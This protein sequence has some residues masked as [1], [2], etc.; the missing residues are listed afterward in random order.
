VYLEQYR[1]NFGRLEAQTWIDRDFSG[2]VQYLMIPRETW[3][4]PPLRLAQG[5]FWTPKP[6]V[7]PSTFVEISDW[8]IPTCLAAPTAIW[9][10]GFRSRH[11]RRRAGLCPQCGYHLR[12]SINRCPECGTPIP[13]HPG[14]G[15]EKVDNEPRGRQRVGIN[16]DGSL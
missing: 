10:V 4:H 15:P 2:T 3:D 7:V 8:L 6:N 14:E 9:L 12:A 13:E 5:D 1:Q 11:A 16:G